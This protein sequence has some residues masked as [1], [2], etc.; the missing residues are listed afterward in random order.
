MK[1]FL[2]IALVLLSTFSL[3]AR[4]GKGNILLSSGPSFTATYSVKD[5]SSVE[6]F[7]IDTGVEFQL[8]DSSHLMLI[9]D[10]NLGYPCMQ[11]FEFFDYNTSNSLVLNTDCF[12]GLGF[13]TG[14]DRRTSF[15]LGAGPYINSINVSNGDDPYFSISL[16]FEVY[17]AAKVFITDHWYLGSALRSGM[18][19]MDLVGISFFKKND[20]I[21]PVAANSFAITG[22]ISG[23]Y[24]F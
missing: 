17:A 23:G 12:V 13:N 15:T 3:C 22:R 8:G 7:G 4:E 14:F 24:M 9:L 2:V 11:D 16:G 20:E 21:R 6:S 10:L 5:H 19:G 1:K 18:T